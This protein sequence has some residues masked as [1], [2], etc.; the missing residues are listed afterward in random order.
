M[1]E[2][3]KNEG[4]SE[5]GPRIPWGGPK[6]DAE[7]HFSNNGATRKPEAKIPPTLL[8]KPAKE[9]PSDSSDSNSDS[10]SW[11][12]PKLL[13]RSDKRPTPA[14]IIEPPPTNTSA[15]GYHFDMKLKV[16]TIPHWDENSD[17]LARWLTKV[18]RLAEGSVEVHREL[19][20]VVPRKFTGSAKTWYYSILNRDW[21]NVEVN[22]TTL[23]KVI[24]AYSIG[25][26]LATPPVLAT[27][28]SYS[29][30]T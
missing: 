6:D 10:D 27:N 14:K 4:K 12:P 19:G 29:L 23:R 20:R 11:G 1:L 28:P 8:N 13:P 5:C 3:G 26:V 21:V 24:S 2:G 25:P 7:N 17:T 30:K 18:N 16:E 9:P 15:E 22:W